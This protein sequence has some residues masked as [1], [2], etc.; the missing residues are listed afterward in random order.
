MPLFQRH[1]LMSLYLFI[2]ALYESYS[3]QSRYERFMRIL[4]LTDALQDHS[5][6]FVSFSP[7]HQFIQQTVA[8]RSAFI[9]T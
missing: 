5:S 4:K 7:S 8:W 6:V 2:P 1:F 9:Y 3:F